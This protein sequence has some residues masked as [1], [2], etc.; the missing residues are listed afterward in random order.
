MLS[1]Q[2]DRDHQSRLQLIASDFSPLTEASVIM[3][4]LGEGGESDGLY[5]GWAYPWVLE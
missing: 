5:R 3:A 2:D 4:A 1:L